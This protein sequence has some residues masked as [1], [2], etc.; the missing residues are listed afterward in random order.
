M[1]VLGGSH[2]ED[3]PEDSLAAVMGL[4]LFRKLLSSHMPAVKF[5]IQIMGRERQLGVGKSLDAQKLQESRSAGMKVFSQTVA[6]ADIML[7]VLAVDG[8][9]GVRGQGVAG[10]EFVMEFLEA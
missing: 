3:D 7:G 6:Q 8:R 2:P 10:I 9:F 1:G 5:K 4:D